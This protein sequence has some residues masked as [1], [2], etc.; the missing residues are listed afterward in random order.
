MNLMNLM[1]VIYCIHT[2]RYGE[3]L[4]RHLQPNNGIKSRK[5]CF[6]SSIMTKKVYLPFYQDYSTAA[7]FAEK[8]CKIKFIKCISFITADNIGG[9]YW[10]G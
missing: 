2:K 3:Y 6:L 1:N 7:L 8:K 10:D 5:R 4:K 9:L